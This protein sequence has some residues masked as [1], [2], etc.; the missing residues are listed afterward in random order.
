MFDVIIIGGGPAGMG[1]ALNLL[2]SGRT[3]LILEKEAFGGQMA[4]S[5]R[6]ENIPGIKS[7]SGMEFSDQLFEQITELGAEFELGEVAKIKKDESGNFQVVT[8]F[9]TY[10]AKSVVIATGCSHRTMGLPK[11]DKFVGKG[12]SYCAVC[13]GAF[14]KGK[15]ISIIG[16]ANTALQYALLLSNYCTKVHMYCLFDR[17]FADKILIDRVLSDKKI[18][19]T[20]E[21]NLEEFIG[22]DH[23]EGL[24]FHSNRDDTDLVVNTEGVFIAIG[25]IPHNEPFKDIVNLNEK[26][27]IITDVNMGTREPGIFAI[28][29][30]REKTVRQVSTALGDASVAAV[31]V[32]RYLRNK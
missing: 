27:F 1:A 12:I 15:E 28:G 7:I 10:E 24:R 13:D 19:I 9:D 14:Y 6:I 23:L 21:V 32:D 16:D 18:D 11:E 26:G 29:D 30:C 5:P 22:I 2:R 17:L 20:Y 31:S 3:V 8:S 25:Q 4:T